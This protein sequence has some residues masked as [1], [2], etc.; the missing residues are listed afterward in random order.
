MSESSVNTIIQDS[1]GFIWLGTKD[2]LNRF[3]GAEFKVFRKLEHDTL[4]IG[5]NFIR[6]LQAVNDSIL[7]V[8]TDLGVYEMNTNLESFHLL[9]VRQ[10]NGAPIRS[11]VN[12]FYLMEQLFGLEPLNK[13]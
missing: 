10:S 2:G 13:V 3:D 1:R 5:N 12:S 8:G 6:A 9:D 4:S 7:F 11:A